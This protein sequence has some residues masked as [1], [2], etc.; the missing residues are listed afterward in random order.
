MAPAPARIPR[1]AFPVSP[2]Q[3]VLKTKRDVNCC[4]REATVKLHLL[5][6]MAMSLCTASVA[7]AQ[8]DTILFRYP[9]EPMKL[10]RFGPVARL[11]AVLFAKVDECGGSSTNYGSADGI[12]G[13]K[14]RQAIKD[15]LN[16]YPYGPVLAGGPAGQ[17]FIT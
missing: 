9:G 7:H 2:A 5:A 4:L 11:Q 15:L 3:A 17:G 12:Y 1:P 10:G 13:A 8:Q 14:T 6:M 16:C